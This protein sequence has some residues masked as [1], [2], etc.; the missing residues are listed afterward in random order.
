VQ[1]LHRECK[2]NENGEGYQLRES[3]VP[4]GGF[5]GAEKEDIGPKN[6][7]TPIFGILILS[8]Q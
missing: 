5:L 7:K 6:L 4:Y 3:S 1:K 2:I 8:N